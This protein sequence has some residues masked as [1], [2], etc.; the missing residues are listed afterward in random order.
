[1]RK[2]ELVEGSSGAASKW[3][4]WWSRRLVTLLSLEASLKPVKL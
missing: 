1:M 3:R 2:F 4:T